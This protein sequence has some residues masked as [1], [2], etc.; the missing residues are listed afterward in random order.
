MILESIVGLF[1]ARAAEAAIGRIQ[2][3]V[4][5][6]S[7]ATVTRLYVEALPLNQQAEHNPA[8]MALDRPTA[9]LTLDDQRAATNKRCGSSIPRV[10]IVG[11]GIAGLAA[12][13]TLTARGIDDFILLEGSSSVGG[14][15]R[16]FCFEGR[17]VEAGANWVAGLSKDNP[18]HQLVTELGI[19]GELDLQIRPEGEESSVIA[20]RSSSGEPLDAGDRLTALEAAME[21]A[22][23]VTEEHPTDL[24]LLEALRLA[25]WEASSCLDQV[26]ALSASCDVMFVGDGEI[27]GERGIEK[28]TVS[29]LGQ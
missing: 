1:S 18:V 23:V 7:A 24:S 2:Q 12:A 27:S 4:N 3:R 29:G 6:T 9:G 28:G 26:I 13:H 15:L 25:G 19:E 14:R 21:Q 11:A 22:E 17:T 10:A 16:S 5:G 20:V 8:G